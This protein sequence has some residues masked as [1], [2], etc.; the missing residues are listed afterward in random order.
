MK[1]Y[2]FFNF[3]FASVALESRSCE[4]GVE[5]HEWSGCGCPAAGPRPLWEEGVAMIG[6]FLI[7]QSLWWAGAIAREW[8]KKS[9]IKTSKVVVILV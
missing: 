1:K 9:P 5:Q 2:F 3:F 6:A 4:T 7:G 8:G